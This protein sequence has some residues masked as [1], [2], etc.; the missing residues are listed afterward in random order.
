MPRKPEAYRV[1]GAA[2]HAPC[3]GVVLATT[4]GIPD[5]PA[6]ILNREQMAGNHVILWCESYEVMLGH[7]R[8][9]S[10]RVAPGRTARAG[11]IIG[12]VG[13]TGNSD[14]PHLHISAQRGGTKGKMDGNPIHLTF[15][16]RTLYRGSCL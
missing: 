13:N 14:E 3:S 2:I 4:D 8:R 15:A 11:D 16:G 7:M 10:V 1:F 5:Q 12:E 6:G 9:G